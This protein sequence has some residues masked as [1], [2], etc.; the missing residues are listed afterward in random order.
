M[1]FKLRLTTLEDYPE[2]YDWF[3]WHRWSNPP[4]IELLD[5]LR[6][7]LMVSY[8]GENIF[9]GFIYFTNANAF[10][11]MEFIVSTY[12]FKDKAIRKE[13]IEFLILSLIELAE[14]K[15]AKVIFT[16]L[17]NTHLINHYNNCGFNVSTKNNIEM[18]K[19]L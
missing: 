14:K 10:S 5:N 17:K 1:Q 6:F 11:L 8:K 12:K 16:Y 4:T 7:G 15:G 2:L 13:A 3:K 9:A 19:V 18:I